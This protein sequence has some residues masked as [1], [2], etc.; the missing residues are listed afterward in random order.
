MAI[1]RRALMLPLCVL[2]AAPVAADKYEKKEKKEAA[3]DKKERKADSSRDKKEDAADYKKQRAADRHWQKDAAADYK[4]QRAADRAWQKWEA[5]TE[6]KE[7]RARH[8]YRSFSRHH[9]VIYHDYYARVYGPGRCPPG[10]VASYGNC[11]W[12]GY[13]RK[14]YAV[15][16]MIR[17]D[18]P[19]LLAPVELVHEIGEPP[20]GYLYV[21]VDGDLLEILSDSRLVV[22]VIDGGYLE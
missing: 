6:W 5:A 20:P 1:I 2:V 15:G 13:S 14:R 21:I 8:N 3:T 4:Q 7:W 10:Y 11:Y 19:I 18:V 16:E 22:D 9:F 17:D 12:P